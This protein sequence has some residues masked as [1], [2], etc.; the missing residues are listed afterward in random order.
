M[1]S[2]NKVSLILKAIGII[3]IV[4][5]FLTGTLYGQEQDATGKADFSFSTAL[6]WWVAGFVIGMLFVGFSE[7]INILHRMDAKIGYAMQLHEEDD[8]DDGA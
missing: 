3:I 2:R 1:D 7:V 5:L 4:V 6:P 8:D